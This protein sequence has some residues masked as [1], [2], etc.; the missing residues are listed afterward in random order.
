[1]IFDAEVIRGCFFDEDLRVGQ[2]WD[3]VIS[4]MKKNRIKEAGVADGYLVEY[5]SGAHSR[6]SNRVESILAVLPIFEKYRMDHNDFT[7]FMFFLYNM[8][9]S[10]SG[11][12]SLLWLFKELIKA[13]MKKKEYTFVFKTILKRL[14]GRIEIY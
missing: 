10:G 7:T 8:V 6:I 11:G 3:F 5:N 2:D 1:L 9:P 12:S 14:F 13:K 4:V